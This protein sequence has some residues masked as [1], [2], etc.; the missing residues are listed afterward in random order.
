MSSTSVDAQKAITIHGHISATPEQFAT[1]LNGR[2]SSTCDELCDVALFI[3]N[4]SAGI[5]QATVDLWHSY[6]ELL[7]PRAVLVTV[8]DG[9]ELD[10]DDAVMLGNRLFDQLVTP[11]LVL[12]GES[13]T[14]I[15][16]ISLENLETKDYSTTPP[17]I[18]HADSE[19]I[20]MVEEFRDEYLDLISE[21][22]E[23][24]FA[25]GILFPAIPV[26]PANGLGL[27]IVASYLNELPSRS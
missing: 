16:T 21:M 11:Y 12:H 20:E 25:S 15:G 2:A 17:T 18:S 5:D 19:L 24:G 6:D 26:N 8:L 23:G 1:I 4:P 22:G 13:G 14:P 7:T 27:D 9:M 3:I 10:F